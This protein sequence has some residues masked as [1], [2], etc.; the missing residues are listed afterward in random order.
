M[1]LTR[2]EACER[3]NVSRETLRKLIKSG[4]LKAHKTS[5]GRTSP[6]RISEEAIRDYVKRHET[7]AAS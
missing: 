4:E 3:L 1:Y 7:L 5:A 6:Y 2:A